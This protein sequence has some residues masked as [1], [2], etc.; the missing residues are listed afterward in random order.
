MDKHE[1]LGGEGTASKTHGSH[2]LKA[3]HMARTSGVVPHGSVPPPDA[4]IQQHRKEKAERQ[5]HQQD[6]KGES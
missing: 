5:Q 6:K 1:H 4:E 2:E 3:E